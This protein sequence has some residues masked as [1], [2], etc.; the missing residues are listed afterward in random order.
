MSD[1]INQ[2]SEPKK[3][4][5]CH[6]RVI[7]IALCGILL[8]LIVG[9]LITYNLINKQKRDSTAIISKILSNFSSEKSIIPDIIIVSKNDSSTIRLDST[10]KKDLIKFL[11]N[12]YTTNNPGNKKIFDI[13]PYLSSTDIRDEDKIVKHIEFLVNAVNKA[14]EESKANIDTE[15]SKINTWVTIWIGVIGFLG[16]FFPLIINLKSLDELKSIKSKSKEAKND[17]A[18]AKRDSTTAKEMLDKYKTHLDGL[19][20]NMEKVDRFENSIN[21]QEL[22]IGEI[23]EKATKAE[24]VSINTEKSLSLITLIFKLKDVDYA[25]L[26]HQK[27][28]LEVLA[29]YLEEIHIELSDKAIDFKHPFVFDTLR[30]LALRLYVLAPYPFISKENMELFN[31]LSGFITTKLETEI[32]EDSFREILDKLDNLIATIKS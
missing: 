10:L 1:T 29:K 11:T 22:R 4:Y 17:A 18:I 14:V 25:F 27:K 23:N 19:E 6:Y 2:K 3:W 30:Q 28:P 12:K 21:D 8:L 15:M 16:I 7:G 20:E 32:T 13:K 24:T 26:V 5:Q 31:D 9:H